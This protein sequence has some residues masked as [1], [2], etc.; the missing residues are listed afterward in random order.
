MVALELGR[1]AIGIDLQGDYFEI[2]RKRAG[3]AMAHA[4]LTDDPDAYS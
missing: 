4:R 3:E 1:D 2:I